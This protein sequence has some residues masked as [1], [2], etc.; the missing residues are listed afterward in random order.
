MHNA[1]PAPLLSVVALTLACSNELPPQNETE[2]TSGPIST[3]G[4]TTYPN[5][6]TSDDDVSTTQNSTLPEESSSTLPPSSNSDT[7]TNTDPS[8]DS[9][10]PIDTTEMGMSTDTTSSTA[11]TGETTSGTTSEPLATC[12][13]G[14]ENNTETDVDC[15]GPDCPACDDELKCDLATDCASQVCTDQACAAPTCFDGATNQDE[16][17]IDC[18]G[19]A[20]AP[21]QLPGLILNEVDYDNVST[22]SAEFVEV[23]NN[24]GAD[25]DLA[26]IHLVLVSDI[27]A[28]VYLD[29]PLG[30]GT[31]AHGQYL[32]VAPVALA[33]PPEAI[34]VE[35]TKVTGNIQNETE[36]VAL[37]DAAAG[38]L[39]DALSYKGSITMAT[40]P[41]IAGPVSLVEGA[42]FAGGDSNSVQRSI[43]R[44]PNGNDKNNALTDWTQSTTPTPGL[45][46]VP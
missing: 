1:W 3:D 17:D 29:L 30:P 13:D 14:L 9:T 27:V 34:K 44:F 42:A 31:L 25:V 16:T 36:G 20:C 33:V 35:F 39:L 32:V 46:N 2:A 37:V 6:T 41:G 15:G 19:A 4:S 38:T 12:V 28:N 22:D 11:E 24:T 23:Y 45:A 18:G 10:S 26:S 43:S 40:L 8:G 7:E 21:C 5:P